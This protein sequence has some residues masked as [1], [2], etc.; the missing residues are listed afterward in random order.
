[1]RYFVPTDPEAGEL[2]CYN[3][4]TASQVT[5][6]ELDDL[7]ADKAAE[8]PDFKEVV[9]IESEPVKAEKPKVTK[10]KATK[11]KAAKKKAAKK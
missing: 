6:A 3:G 2:K 8:N 10:K 9:L 7:F 5:P 11:K 1:M 4:T